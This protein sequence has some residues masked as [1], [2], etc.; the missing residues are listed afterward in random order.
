MEAGRSGVGDD[1]F[2]RQQIPYNLKLLDYEEY[3]GF[4]NER[5]KRIAKEMNNFLAELN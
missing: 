4:L 3:E 2:G 5:S 1:L